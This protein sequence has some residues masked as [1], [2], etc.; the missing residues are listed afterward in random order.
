MQRIESVAIEPL[1]RKLID[2]AILQRSAQSI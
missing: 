1:V 2:R